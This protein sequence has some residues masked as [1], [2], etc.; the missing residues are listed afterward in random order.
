MKKDETDEKERDRDHVYRVIYALH[1]LFVRIALLKDVYFQKYNRL[2]S[3]F[4]ME[5]KMI[6]NDYFHIVEKSDINP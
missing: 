4:Q 1:V 5:R 2:L 3:F 6:F